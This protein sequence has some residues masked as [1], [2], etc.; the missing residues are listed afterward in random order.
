MRSFWRWCQ[1]SHHGCVCFSGKY[2]GLS[3]VC[4]YFSRKI[5][6]GKCIVMV[7]CNEK[8]GWDVGK[9]AQKEKGKRHILPNF[10]QLSLYIFCII[11][12]FAEWCLHRAVWQKAW[13]CTSYPMHCLCKQGCLSERIPWWKE[14]PAQEAPCGDGSMG[15][16]WIVLT[17]SW[18]QILVGIILVVAFGRTWRK[19]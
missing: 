6:K 13:V 17:P 4:G 14:Q 18:I 11:S 12:F 10:I 5:F 7:N 9:K 1:H 19:F 3:V 2:F 16:P 8:L 15:L